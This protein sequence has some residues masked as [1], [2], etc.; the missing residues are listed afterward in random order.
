VKYFSVEEAEA[1]IPELERI[2]DTVAELAAKA[3][4]KAEAVDRLERAKKADPSQLAI[5][6]SQLQ[7]LTQA[8]NEQLQS[9]VDLGAVPKGL[10]PALVDFPARVEGREAYLC[11]KLGEKAITHYHGVEEGFGG[12]K[13][14]KRTLH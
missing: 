5:E 4:A 12:R 6:Q 13:P 11:W 1:L 8:A 7:F 9:I 10:E 2:F 3:Q 14:L